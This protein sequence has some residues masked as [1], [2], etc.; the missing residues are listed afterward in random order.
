MRCIVGVILFV[1]NLVK[2]IPADEESCR[3]ENFP[4]EES[5]DRISFVLEEDEKLVGSLQRDTRISLRLVNKSPEDVIFTSFFQESFPSVYIFDANKPRVELIKAVH[6]RQGLLDTNST[7][8]ILVDLHEFYSAP[9]GHRA[10]VTVSITLRTRNTSDTGEGGRR[11]QKH[12][13]FHYLVSDTTDD[14]VPETLKG[15]PVCVINSQQKSPC[16]RDQCESLNRE[17]ELCEDY[18]WEASFLVQE[19][20][21]GLH[22]PKVLWPE[23]AY[24]VQS[25]DVTGT[26]SVSELRVRAPC[27]DLSLGVEVTSLGGDTGL[28]AIGERSRAGSYRPSSEEEKIVFGLTKI[29]F[30]LFTI[31]TSNVVHGLNKN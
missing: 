18:F 29:L 23:S 25:W 26:V 6:P 10:K 17:T 9:P 19:S 28:C 30:T 15:A 24:V 13:S 21:T 31:F 7:T 1:F 11:R 27:C 5:D 16:A 8:L 22:S 2:V 20:V 14:P 4:D 3:I 12:V